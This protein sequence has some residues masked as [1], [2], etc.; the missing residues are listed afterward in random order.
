MFGI[1]RRW[2]KRAKYVRDIKFN[3]SAENVGFQGQ[4]IIIKRLAFCDTKSH[5]EDRRECRSSKSR[6]PSHRSFLFPQDTRRRFSREHLEV[7]Q[8][9]AF[10]RGFQFESRCVTS[11]EPSVD[12]TGAANRNDYARHSNGART[13]L[14]RVTIKPLFLTPNTC[15]RKGNNRE[16]ANINSFR[17]TSPREYPNDD[18]PTTM[19]ALRQQHRG[20]RIDQ[21]VLNT[22]VRQTVIPRG[23]RG[24]EDQPE[25]RLDE[26]GQPL[27]Q[28]ASCPW[29]WAAEREGEC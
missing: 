15:K 1:T 13:P 4:R 28:V 24:D 6:T 25:R 2:A 12:L 10:E 8:R 21:I 19:S 3:V 22:R 18:T 11:N 20:E 7:T 27:R 23:V 29:R 26:F 16:T 14:A 17:I 5:R 9:I